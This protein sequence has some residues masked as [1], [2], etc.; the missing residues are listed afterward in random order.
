MSAISVAVAGKADIAFL[1]CICPLMT[2]SRHLVSLLRHH[3][4]RGRGFFGGWRNCESNPRVPAVSAVFGAEFL[5]AL[6]AQVTLHIAHWK[7]EP[8][9]RADTKYARFEIT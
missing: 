8:N 2:Q 7:D 1:R 6:H 4:S 9:L 5:V 3:P